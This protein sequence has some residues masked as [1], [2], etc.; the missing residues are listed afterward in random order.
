MDLAT[1]QSLFTPYL[2]LIQLD[3]TTRGSRSGRMTLRRAYADQWVDRDMSLDTVRALKP[4]LNRAKVCH[5]QGWGEPLL[6]PDFFEMVRIANQCG[7]LTATAVSDGSLIDETMA[8]ELVHSGLTSLTFS[9]SAL[10]DRENLDRRGVNLATV[11]Q[12]LEEIKRHQ[13]R[14]GDKTAISMLYSMHRG[15]V[16]SLEKFPSIFQGLGV[17]ALIVNTLSFTPDQEGEEETLVPEDQEEFDR[18]HEIILDTAAKAKKRDMQLHAF[19]VHGGKNPPRCIEK[20]DAGCFVKF[21][22]TVAPCIFSEP[23]LEGQA[24]YRFQGMNMPFKRIRFG[25]IK[26]ATFKRIWNTPAYKEFRRQFKQ[27]GLPEACQGCWRPYI[28]ALRP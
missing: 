14:F 2:D 24:T 23:P 27:T 3:V 18:L 20:L 17:N 16:E 10:N 21:D 15:D 22:G 11:F 6:N 13:P 8:R 4:A 12:A 9:I 19:V 5:L 25:S 26:Q 7:C 1:L 28:K